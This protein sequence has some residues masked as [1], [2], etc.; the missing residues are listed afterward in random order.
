[1]ELKLE[2]PQ[3]FDTRGIIRHPTMLRSPKI[4][5]L[6]SILDDSNSTRIAHLL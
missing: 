2:V 1:M 6:F 5:A 3:N 4:I